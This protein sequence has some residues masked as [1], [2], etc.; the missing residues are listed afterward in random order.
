MATR[1]H[2]FSGLALVV[3]IVVVTGTVALLAPVAAAA[4]AAPCR[5]TNLRTGTIYDG[6]GPNLQ[7]A[8]DAAGF[9]ATL[10]VRGVC[11]GSF[12]I[13]RSLEL[14]GVATAAFPTPTLDG[15]AAGRVLTIRAGSVSLDD[16][17]ITDGAV[18]ADVG[19]GG[20]SNA[21]ALT[22]RGS[23]SVS[24]NVAGDRGGGI[25]SAHGTLVMN[26]S[27]SVSG[28]IAL[29]SLGGGVLVDRGRF[30]M[31]GNASVSGNAAGSYGGGIYTTGITTMT[32]R[33]SVN[34]NAAGYAGGGIYVA[35][36]GGSLTMRRSSS[37]SDNTAVH[38]GGG[39]ISY[40]DVVLNG[41]SMVA[42]NAAGDTGGGI[43]NYY[44]LLTMNGVS[45]VSGNTA[46]DGGGGIYSHYATFAMNG[47]A[48]V[49]GN[50]ADVDDDS[51]G[52]GGGVL[53]CFGTLTGAVDGS[54]V[55][56]N[57]L[58]SSGTIED[59]IAACR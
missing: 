41:S 35:V 6:T 31:N 24:G 11:V 28:N 57:Y 44:G 49:W 29:G 27:S 30:T 9:G 22:L 50:R 47:S 51:T 8:I 56:A 14:I 46:G 3:S 59:N 20:I 37:V 36:G 33:A 32:D 19:G 53:H 55:D 18:P 23:T 54:N 48:S 13:S 7:Q 12:T 5:V 15:D 43:A 4:Q 10:R 2:R 17:L 25:L 38:G 26:G 40:T 52:T 39:I 45:T 34:G 42:N 21:G 16:L 1:R 58:G